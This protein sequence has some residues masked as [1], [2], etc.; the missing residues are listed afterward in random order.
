MNSKVRMILLYFMNIA[1][2]YGVCVQKPTK[3]TTN[4]E[5]KCNFC[6]SQGPIIKYLAQNSLLRQSSIKSQLV[7]QCLNVLD[8]SAD[9]CNGFMIQYTVNF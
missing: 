3:I 1:A 2:V 8:V 9:E 4:M 6:I 7:Q 5:A